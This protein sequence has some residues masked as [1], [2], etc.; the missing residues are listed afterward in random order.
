M[1]KH[2]S[3]AGF[4]V[5]PHFLYNIYTR[6]PP[7]F[8][9][10]FLIDR[11]QLKKIPLSGLCHFSRR[12]LFLYLP[13]LEG[14]SRTLFPVKKSCHQP[15]YL[16]P[17]AQLGQHEPLSCELCQRNSKCL[18][19]SVR[20]TS[21]IIN[22]TKLVVFNACNQKVH[23]PVSYECGHAEKEGEKPTISL[24]GISQRA[25]RFVSLTTSSRQT[26]KLRTKEWKEVESTEIYG[27]KSFSWQRSITSYGNPE[28]STL[29]SKYFPPKE[30][31]KRKLSFDLSI[32][33]R[34]CSVWQKAGLECIQNT[35][36]LYG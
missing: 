19:I 6:A 36:S 29:H 13:C 20:T 16:C 26:M 14:E 5:Q 28:I 32:K 12:F 23:W 15:I 33:E 30:R 22:P 18:S 2:L 3:L 27:R 9:P 8:F 31:E 21:P 25:R 4:F 24:C 7:W 10:S 11:T 35:E 34:N 17:I 1:T